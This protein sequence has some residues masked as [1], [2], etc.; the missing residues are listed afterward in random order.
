MIARSDSVLRL[1]GFVPPCESGMGLGKGDTGVLKA[2]LK[3]GGCV[4]YEGIEFC[5]D[6]EKWGNYVI[7]SKD[8]EEGECLFTVPREIILSV[9]NTRIGEFVSTLSLENW[10][11]L[12]L[13][14]LYEYAHE[15]SKFEAYFSVLPSKLN[16]PLFWN[17]ED[18]KLLR[19]TSLEDDSARESI[20]ANYHKKIVPLLVEHEKVFG[21]LEFYSL[22]MYTLFGSIVRAYSFTDLSNVNE[23]E[24]EEEEELTGGETMMVPMA[25]MLN[26]VTGQN[27]AR[28]FFEE[29]CLQMFSICPIKKGEQIFNTYGDLGNASLLENFGFVDEE[30]EFNY[31][32]VTDVEVMNS[33]KGV[34]SFDEKA[35]TE[36]LSNVGVIPGI[37]H[38]GM[39]T[40]FP[41][42]IKCIFTVCTE[43][44]TAAEKEED[45]LEDFIISAPPTKLLYTFFE[46][47]VTKRLENYPSLTPQG[48][49]SQLAKSVQESERIILDAVKKACLQK[50]SSFEE[51]AAKSNFSASSSS[52]S[53]SRR[54]SRSHKKSRKKRKYNSQMQRD[55]V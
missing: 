36:F 32:T 29:D 41:D 6:E 40:M 38:L 37:Y 43:F 26:H 12:I 27:N 49:H 53:N 21:N 47:L 44:R 50:I 42:E 51:K 8:I 31:V 9:G 10:D 22:E 45:E 4:L 46:K 30:N 52:N 54:T 48:K 13:C 35:C 3:K 25:D 23:E 24:E 11:P 1:A 14:M 39:E 20:V 7:A 33:L 55:C 17:E 18:L 15:G 28:L 34:A 19:N 16:T 5:S 2:W